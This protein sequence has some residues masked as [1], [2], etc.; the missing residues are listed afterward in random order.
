M[1][2]RVFCTYITVCYYYSYCFWYIV[3]IAQS[4]LQLSW[5]LLL[6]AAEPLH[7]TE[8]DTQELMGWRHLRLSEQI[9]VTAGHTQHWFLTS[10]PCALGRVGVTSASFT[11]LLYD[12]GKVPFPLWA[13]G[14]HASYEGLDYVS[15]SPETVT[16]F[17][18]L[19]FHLPCLLSS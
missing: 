9:G 15:V 14:P 7:Y 13:W 3:S 4:F 12:T 18:Y 5:T 6:L 16:L 19:H 8:G 17:S 2:R 10:Q 1:L 11:V